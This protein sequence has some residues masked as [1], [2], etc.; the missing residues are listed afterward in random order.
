MSNVWVAVG[1][2]VLATQCWRVLAAALGP[3]VAGSRRAAAAVDGMACAVVAGVVANMVLGPGT[4]AL[5]GVPAEVR[6]VSL[7]LAVAAYFACRRSVPAGVAVGF[8]AL[9]AAAAVSG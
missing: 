4:G 8:A 1:V 7:A 9:T 3:R 2:A 5:G 6:L